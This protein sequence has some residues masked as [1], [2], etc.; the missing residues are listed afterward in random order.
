NLTR[1]C[2]NHI[3]ASNDMLEI[4]CGT[5]FMTDEV[6]RLNPTANILA[7]D[8]AQNMV[9]VCGA[10]LP[11]I[12]T[13]VMD[14]E[15][16]TVKNKYDFVYSNLAFQWFND[17]PVTINKYK[18]LLNENGV[19]AFSTL[20]DKNFSQWQESCEFS[21]LDNRQKNF[22]SEEQIVKSF[23]DDFD[24]K[25]EIEILDMQFASALDF[26]SHLRNIGARGDSDNLPVGKLK[27]ACKY[28]NDKHN[29]TV[30]Y[31]VI[32]VVAT[33]K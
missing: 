23:G 4:G 31:Y 28:L 19:L 24:V 13:M 6:F 12:E 5:G 26:L 22:L 16:P 10:K 17:L 1:I 25:I 29:N 32:Y 20:S 8:I 11:N 33:R 9:N 3:M 30:S 27:K 2:T 14:G 21:G 7:T 15:N 18:D